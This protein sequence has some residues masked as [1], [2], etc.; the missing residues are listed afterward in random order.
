VSP[1]NEILLLEYKRPIESGNTT[2]SSNVVRSIQLQRRRG[3]PTSIVEVPLL[4]VGRYKKNFI[5]N[6]HVTL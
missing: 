2:T 1:W 6:S 4:G 3:L 5:E